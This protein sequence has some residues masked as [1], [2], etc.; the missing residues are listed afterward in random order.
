[1]NNKKLTWAD[2]L[3]L[4]ALFRAGISVKD[5]ALELSFSRQTIY[6]ELKRGRYEH[7][8]SDYTVE[9]RYSPDIAQKK[10]EV[11]K[12]CKGPGLKI[13]DDFELADF[14]EYKI[15]SEHY[16][17]GAVLGEIKSMGLKFKTSISKTTLY[18]Y[19]DDELFLTI[20][21]KDLPVKSKKSN[22]HYK[23]VKAARP[24]KGTSIEKRPDEV[25]DRDSFGH[26]E[27]DCVVSKQGTLPAL[28][29]LTERLTRE[30]LVRLMPDKTSLSVV[31]CINS[32]EKS[33]GKVLFSKIFKTI[34]VDNGNEFADCYGI[35][36]SRDGSERTKVYY[37]HPYSS[38]ERGSNENQNKLIR[39]FF[40]KGM[41]FN[42]LTKRQVSR[43]EKWINNYPRKLFGWHTSEDLFKYYFSKLL[44]V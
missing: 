19:I 27:M 11:N 42:Y 28:L 10:W 34:T 23:K 5:I 33:Y 37:C 21:N 29:V 31:R 3:K 36:H 14:I 32:L 12:V 44:A 41:D 30:E 18:R 35:E 39:R 7:L 40:P 22:R 38:Y 20:T 16:S 1:M 25:M 17:P 26:W 15:H 24:P 4:D 9:E 8:N 6:N 13:S 43:V 2:R